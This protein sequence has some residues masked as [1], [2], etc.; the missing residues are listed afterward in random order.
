M[1]FG[2]WPVV[3]GGCSKHGGHAERDHPVPARTPQLARR[4]LH[5]PAWKRVPRTQPHDCHVHG[6]GGF[7]RSASV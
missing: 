2:M 3:G 4:R 1:S 7:A 6:G 5:S